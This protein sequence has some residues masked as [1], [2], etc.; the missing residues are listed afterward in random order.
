MGLC[1][2]FGSQ[3][4]E[5]CDHPMR[6]GADA[7]T[8]DECGIVCSGLFDAC[9]DVW[10]RG[11]HPVLLVSRPR[12]EVPAPPVRSPANGQQRRQ[13]PDP[14]PPPV[15]AEVRTNG[16]VAAPASS[17]DAGRTEVFRWFEREFGALRDEVAGLRAALAQEHAGNA[18]LDG[19]RPE[20]LATLVD[21]AVAKALANHL[22]PL[23]HSVT[24]V[25]RSLRRE[26]KETRLSNERSVLALRDAIAESRSVP[27]DQLAPPAEAVADSAA[28]SESLLTGLA[29]GAA[30]SA[31]QS[32]AELAALRRR[33]DRVTRGPAPRPS[34]SGMAPVGPADEELPAQA[35]PQHGVRI[36]MRDHA[37][38]G[39]PRA[40]YLADAD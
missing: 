10:A 28:H 2:D 9:T 3:I 27:G 34:G 5:H 26:L 11:P 38:S 12:I 20:Q 1:H 29:E 19:A 4:A 40:A 35:Q 30:D 21:E 36:S 25:L 17:A 39:S 33:L 14:L 24:G 16:A 13:E 6:A 22:A 15:A 37:A 18:A 31:S 8:C 32:A 7:C 23:E